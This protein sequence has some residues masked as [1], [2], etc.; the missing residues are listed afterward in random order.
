MNKPKKSTSKVKIQFI[1]EQIQKQKYKQS[2]I[3]SFFKKENIQEDTIVK[4]STGNIPNYKQS[5]IESFLVKKEDNNF[6]IIET[7]PILSVPLPLTFPLNLVDD[8]V[9]CKLPECNILE[10]VDSSSEDFSEGQKLN[11]T[12]RK[13]KQ[14]HVYHFDDS[15]SNNLKDIVSL[16]PNSIAIQREN[17]VELFRQS[18]ETDSINSTQGVTNIIGK[19]T[20]DNLIDDTKI[21]KQDPLK[22]ISKKKLALYKL[23]TQL[24][25][26]VTK[27]LTI[28]P[29]NVYLQ[30]LI[31]K[32]CDNK[33][34]IL[35]E[36]KYCEVTTLRA[37][38]I[39]V[40][41]HVDSG[42]TKLLDKIRN[43]CVQSKEA[44]GIT[45]QI[46]ATYIPIENIKHFT[47][48]INKM[49]SKSIVS[50]LPGLILIDTPGH[51]SFYN[52]RNKGSSLCD[53]AI[54]VIDVMNGI[55]P[56]TLE[57]INLLKDKKV[58]FIVVLNK[59]DRCYNWQ[60]NHNKLISKLLDG[61]LQDTQ[62]EFYKHYNE[63]VH[64]LNI[65]GLD[66]CLYYE[67]NNFKKRI[68]MI[69]ISSYTGEGVSEMLLLITQLSQNIMKAKLTLSDK[70]HCTIVDVKMTEGFGTTLD[71][72]LV[73]GTL[74]VGDTIV[75]CSLNGPIVTIVKA[76]LTVS[77][78]SN[79]KYVYN[80]SLTGAMCVKIAASNLDDS[81]AGTQ[82][83]LH[84]K[85]N[86]KN[87]LETLKK[88]VMNDLESI[89]NKLDKDVGKTEGI[90]V[91]TSSLGSLEAFIN[92]LKEM[93]I[94]VNG[95]SIGQ[96]YKKDIM[97]ASVANT[98]ECKVILAFDVVIK[99]DMKQYAKEMNVKIIESGVIYHLYEEYIK[100]VEIIKNKNAIKYMNDAIFPCILEIIPNKVINAKNPIILGVKVL[101]GIVKIGTL[102]GIVKNDSL[103]SSVE[104]LHIG[105]IVGI[106]KVCVDQLEAKKGD[107]ISIKIET[108]ETKKTMIY[109][110]QFDHTN[111]LVSILTRSSIDILKAHFKND[112]S[113]SDWRLVIKIKKLLNIL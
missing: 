93:K 75:V 49:L 104:I 2:E 94:N 68:S 31:K 51:R 81:L 29:S 15:L 59:I 79:E 53:L 34:N 108:D 4:Q 88:S 74:Q 96:V 109:G 14:K 54:L 84:D 12:E 78:S 36:A 43:S 64:N 73:N 23:S 46:G 98:E 80:N 9:P 18:I 20:F 89:T 77:T 106:Q 25:E 105:K 27:K 66:A 50:K 102:I 32:D 38:I 1:K 87:N 62:N 11:G 24:P 6:V 56:Q 17:G 91:Q 28:K 5:T 70:F 37:P 19:I 10:I 71:V 22:N 65:E 113:E 67:N 90:Y 69:P 35:E 111:Q 45:Q 55:E 76:L 95:V 85:N 42:K 33:V 72:I 30:K 47:N 86:D 13:I 52:L 61:Q 44:G 103:L 63:I 83:L 16:H 26:K 101:D 92:F 8:L 99:E 82:I 40:L 7:K 58:P 112:L 110:R 41:G 48:D 57:S 60:S 97:K 21:I 100:Y 107:E 39:C 3:D